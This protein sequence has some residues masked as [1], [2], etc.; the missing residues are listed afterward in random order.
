MNLR[1][2]MQPFPEPKELETDL[3]A[4]Y[5]AK[6]SMRVIK[7]KVESADFETF[8]FLEVLKDSDD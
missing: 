4:T 1:Y 3:K 7:G 5:I 8:K 2:L 6:V